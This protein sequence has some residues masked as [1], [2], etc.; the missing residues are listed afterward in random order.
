[1]VVTLTFADTGGTSFTNLVLNS[2]TIGSTNPTTPA[3]PAVVAAVIPGQG[4]VSFVLRFPGSVG[5][6]GNRGVL[7][8]NGVYDQGTVT[9]G[10]RIVFP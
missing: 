9:S 3:L 2:A 8:V 6:P 5:A 1:V 4:S 7:T 10:G